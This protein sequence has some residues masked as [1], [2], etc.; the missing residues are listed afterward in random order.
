[1]GVEL[2]RSK[3]PHFKS[4]IPRPKS[5]FDQSRKE[6]PTNNPMTSENT[7]HS[8]S[9]GIP[10]IMNDMD[11]GQFGQ[12]Y[13]ATVFYSSWTLGLHDERQRMFRGCGWTHAWFRQRAD[14]LAITTESGH[15]RDRC[16]L[17]TDSA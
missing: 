11:N 10:T 14:S 12:G 3:P 8:N 16:I 9:S 15:K 13:V 7:V 1:M 6:N 2:I 17:I 4:L 5:D